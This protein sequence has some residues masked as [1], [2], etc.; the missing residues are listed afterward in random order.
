MTTAAI[1]RT[2]VGEG[3]PTDTGVVLDLRE[4]VRHLGAACD[5]LAERA[6]LADDAAER[7]RAAGSRLNLL[8]AL[9]RVSAE[10][11]RERSR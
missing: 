4:A 2:V 7:A 3:L 11:G 1:T 6:T 10:L 8:N 5:A 9:R